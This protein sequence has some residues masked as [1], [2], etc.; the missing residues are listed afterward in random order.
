MRLAWCRTETHT[1]QEHCTNNGR[2]AMGD[3]V[4]AAWTLC[5]LNYRYS[6]GGTWRS[7]GGTW[8]DLENDNSATQSSP[9][10][11]LS[12]VLSTSSSLLLHR[13]CISANRTKH[14][15]L[16]FLGYNAMKSL[17][18]QPTFPRNVWPRS[19][20]LFIITAVKTAYHTEPTYN[21]ILWIKHRNYYNLLILTSF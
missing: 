15:G 18:S 20:V 2:W 9:T 19:S 21:I 14:E 16:Y 8:G 13:N 1:G 4:P 17:R 3:T 11:E 10:Q 7:L 12:C 6:N 5:V